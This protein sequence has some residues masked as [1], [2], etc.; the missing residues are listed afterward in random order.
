[1][2]YMSSERKSRIKAAV[3]PVLKK[4]GL[5]GSLRKDTHS[6]TLTIRSGNVDFKHL[7]V[8]PIACEPSKF[9]VQ[10]NE[11]W[12]DS[13]WTGTALQVLEE[14]KTAMR[15]ADWYDNSDAMVDYFDTAY[16]PYIH[17]GSWQKGYQYT[18]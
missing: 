18:G 10:V 5:K 3:D 15:A 12:L 14:L 6:I 8:S 17:L 2:A 7:T 11:Y 16:Y 1:M 9:Y 13:H 4:Y